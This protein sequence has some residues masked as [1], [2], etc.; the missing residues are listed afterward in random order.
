MAP[1]KHG[2]WWVALYSLVAVFLKKFWISLLLNLIV[3]IDIGLDQDNAT[4]MIAV[5][6]TYLDKY[7]GISEGLTDL[8]FKAAR[9]FYVSVFLHIL[10][11][12]RKIAKTDTDRQIPDGM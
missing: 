3:F 8:T 9:I 7:F 10:S 2:I 12:S 1:R 6:V 5:G 4:L 11:A